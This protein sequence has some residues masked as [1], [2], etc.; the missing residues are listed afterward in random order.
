MIYLNNVE[1]GGETFF[2]SLNKVSNQL[3]VMH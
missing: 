2:S 3:R 1:K